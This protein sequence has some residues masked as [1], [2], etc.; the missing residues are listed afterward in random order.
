MLF[1]RIALIEFCNSLAPLL[2]EEVEPA[3]DR[4]KKCPM[5]RPMISSRGILAICIISGAGLLAAIFFLA[6]S[7]TGPLRPTVHENSPVGTAAAGTHPAAETSPQMDRS[8]LYASVESIMASMNR[9]QGL[10]LV[11]VRGK[12]A[13]EKYRIPGTIRVPLHALKTKAF[14]KDRPV[15]LVNEGHPNPVLERACRDMRSAG[16]AH[17]S[18]LNGGLRCWQQKNGP[19]EGDAFA[20]IDASRIS[21]IDFFPHHDSVEWLVV[22]VAT[23]AS[24][25]R[26]FR[27]LVPSAIDLP[28]DGNPSAFAAALKALAARGSR[29]PLACILVCDAGGTQYEPIERAVQQE[30]ISRVFYLK[31]GM[32]AYE[33]FAEQQALLQQRGTEEMQRCATCS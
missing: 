33:A 6:P 15:V 20:A 14:L 19:I 9:K 23:P 7:P 5:S 17:V 18:I 13:F 22:R 12:D 11:D 4:R 3:R 32:E 2:L 1:A 31:G 30:G 8:R 29:S 10:L 25:P 26:R 21:P 27:S 28:W 16:F 24:G